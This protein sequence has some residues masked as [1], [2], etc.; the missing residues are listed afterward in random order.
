MTDPNLFKSPAVCWIVVLFNLLFYQQN[1]QSQPIG[2]GPVFI[3]QPPVSGNFGEIRGTHFHT[4]IDFKTGGEEGV[5][6]LAASSGYVSRIR[7]SASGYGKAIYVNHPQLGITTVYGHLRMFY[8]ELEDTVKRF[9]YETKSGDM[10]WFPD[11]LAFPIMKGQLI[12]F[13]GNTG[14]S[15]GPHLHFETRNT[16]SEIPYD[17]MLSGYV[18]P[19]TVPPVI[20]SMIVYQPGPDSGFFGCKRFYPGAHPESSYFLFPGNLFF[21]GFEGWDLAG[22]D[23]NK[24]GIYKADLYLDDSLVFAY[25]IDSVSFN[26]T[27]HV[28]AF[29]DSYKRGPGGHAVTLCLVS[30]G[31]PL[32]CYAS[33]KGLIAIRDS[34]IH[35]VRLSVCDR[36][37]NKS[38]KT[39]D[40]KAIPENIS[41]PLSVEGAMVYMGKKKQFRDRDYKIIVDGKAFYENISLHIEKVSN[42][43]LPVSLTRASTAIRIGP[44]DLVMDEGLEIILDITKNAR[45]YGP[46]LAAVRLDSESKVHYVGG[47]MEKGSMRFKVNSPGIYVIT[48]DDL[49]PIVSTPSWGPDVLTRMR[50]IFIPVSDQLSG[51]AK[52]DLFAGDQWVRSLYCSGQGRIE[53]FPEDM[54][55]TGPLR[56]ILVDRKGNSSEFQLTLPAE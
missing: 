36:M 52:W 8:P 43:A 15:Q 31:N 42:P 33:G 56:L 7:V 4:G 32:P 12:G 20:Y 23:S 53:L 27:R 5:P 16:K 45:K 41:S 21:I 24:L 34:M 10:E 55:K 26:D 14:S 38:E 35:K 48:T 6:V 40:I 1:A 54:P 39:V 44:D 51:I 30:P 19:D 29:V 28:R 17:P 18:Y 2:L 47:Q 25:S 37:G 11:S 22:R 3:A 9:Q 13:S 50:K 49:P 46:K